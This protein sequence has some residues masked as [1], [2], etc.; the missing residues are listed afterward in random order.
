M[1]RRKGSLLGALRGAKSADQTSGPLED[2][3]L[4]RVHE[5]A[6]SAATSALS[7]SQAAGAQAS[8]QRTALE[9]AI[10]SVQNLSSRARDVRSSLDRAREAL[11]QIRIV[12][13][14]AGLEG[15][16]LGDAAGRSLALI[17]EEVREHAGRAQ[18]ALSEQAK[19]L[20]QM[21]AERE[22]LQEHVDGAQQRSAELARELLQ[23]QA[24]QRDAGAALDELGGRLQTVTQTDPETARLVAE[25]AEH[26]R[27]L[28]SALSSLTSKP[29]RASLLGAL[30][31]ALGPLLGLLRELY[32]G[33][34][35]NSSK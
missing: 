33:A 22:R 25:A 23:T 6:T 17:A 20:Q 26:A 12:A 5:R 9:A 10:D 32:K 13:L 27:S 15:A 21:D 34:P 8:Q 1:A 31:P 4:F 3:E 29:H 7:L 2:A 19:A 28:A 16:R 14:N 30:S 18:A 35:D 24:A 11:E